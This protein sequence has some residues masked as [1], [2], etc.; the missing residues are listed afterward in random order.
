MIGL[1]RSDENGSRP[2]VCSS[3]IDLPYSVAPFEI[4][5]SFLGTGDSSRIFELVQ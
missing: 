1:T 4:L 5:G 2:T 3:H